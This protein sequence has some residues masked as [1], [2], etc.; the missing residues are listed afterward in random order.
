MKH[1]SFLCA[2]A[3]FVIVAFGQNDEKP[4][5]DDRGKGKGAGPGGQVEPAVVPQYLF[6]VWLCRAGADSVTLSA[7]AWQDMDVF[8]SYGT[9]STS[10][11]QRSEVVKLRTGEPQ[12]ILLGQL[13]PDTG[14]AYQLT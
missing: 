5:K 4:A 14:Y 1:L 3:A 11:A 10:L 7:L 8:V 6:N 2:L 13:K 9:S 12:T